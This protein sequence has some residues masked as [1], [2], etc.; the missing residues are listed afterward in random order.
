MDIEIMLTNRP[1]C[2]FQ[3]KNQELAKALAAAERNLEDEVYSSRHY[4][5]PP[6]IF[7]Q[8]LFYLLHQI[9]LP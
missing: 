3:A 2:G 8:L 1:S 5:H 6:Q 7:L 4:F 9:K